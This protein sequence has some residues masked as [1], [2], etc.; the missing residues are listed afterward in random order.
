MELHKLAALV[1]WL[2]CLIAW[3]Q[4]FEAA[5]PA[6]NVP[7]IILFGDSTVDVGNNNFLNTIAKS[8][9][10]PYGRDFDTKTPTGRFTDGRMVSDFMASKLGLPMSLPYLHPNA[11]GQNLIYGTNF[12][13]AAS[14]YLDTTSVFLN[15]IPASRQLEMFDEYKIKLSKVVGPEKSS[16]IISQALY[17]VSSGSNDFI[18]N[19]FVNPALQSSY[20]PTEFNAALMSTQTEFVQKLY[21]AGARKIGIFGFPPIGCIPAQITLFGIDVNQKTC[22]EE[23]NAI[24][25]AYNSDL[26]AAIPKWQ[27][28]LSGSL[29][30]YLDAYSMLYDIFNN[31]TKY[32]Y[33]EA[34]RACCGEGLLSTAG[35][36]NK[37]SVGTCTDA[38]KYVFFDSLHPTSSVY[39]LVAEA[40]HEK[41]ISYLL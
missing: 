18:L 9:F 15:V 17:F 37:D 10:L 38:S 35:F 12:A 36:C 32:G 24:A 7:A 29:L 5:A 21:Q 13:S 40:Y 8:N 2:T 34:R 22:V 39:R 19:Y 1:L 27:S 25:S 33:T 23:Q 30:L 16:S 41:V 14:G 3:V 26:A 11:T 28:N 6:V 20:S 31:P 4:G